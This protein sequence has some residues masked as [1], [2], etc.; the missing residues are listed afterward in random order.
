MN[1]NWYQLFK[2]GK[3][4]IILFIIVFLFCEFFYVLEKRNLF[5]L[6]QYENHIYNDIKIKLEGKN[7]SRMTRK[8]R[9]F[10]NGIIRKYRPKKSLEVG[11]FYGGSSVIILNALKDI[12]NSHLFSVDIKKNH[13][14][15]KCVNAYFPYLI[16]K[17]TLFKGD[18]I[19][20]CRIYDFLKI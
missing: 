13:W 20:K 15:G 1:F 12:K 9:M 10:L 17:W 14:V 19:A 11:V 6:D 7:C 18:I 16:N 4:V 8:H 5:Y 3:N 2:S